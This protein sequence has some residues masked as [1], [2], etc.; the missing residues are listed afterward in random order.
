[1]QKPKRGASPEI[2]VR[3]RVPHGG[4]RTPVLKVDELAS[5]VKRPVSRVDPSTIDEE[6]RRN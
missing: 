2:Q 5:P 4:N 1:L 6:Q 3:Q